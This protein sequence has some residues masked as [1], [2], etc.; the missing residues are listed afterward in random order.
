MYE[1]NDHVDTDQAISY[2]MYMYLLVLL[3]ILCPR[4]TYIQQSPSKVKR[5]IIVHH[6][7]RFIYN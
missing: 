1:Y 6:V 5:I 3:R 7:H 2:N 4:E